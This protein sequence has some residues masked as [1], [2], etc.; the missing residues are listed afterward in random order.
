[1]KAYMRVK[2]CLYCLP[3]L[4]LAAPASLH[5]QGAPIPVKP[6]LWETQM[7]VT[8]V[9]ALPPEAEAKIAA[10]PAAQQ[11][12]VR[13]MMGGGAGSAPTVTTKQV[14]MTGQSSMDSMLNRAQQSPG[15]QCTFSNRVQTATGASFDMTCTGATG[16]ATGHT[17]FRLIDSDHVSSTSHMTVTGSSQGHTMNSTIDSTSTAKFVNAD[18]GDVKPFTAPAAQ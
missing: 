6:G 4:L 16:S 7:S 9:M 17:Q 3:V 14:C 10:L 18:C 2:L 8:H 1:M 15:M 12:Q 11:A 13:S 5:A